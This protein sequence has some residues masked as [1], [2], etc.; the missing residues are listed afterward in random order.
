MSWARKFKIKIFT[1]LG[2][3]YILN[4]TVYDFDDTVD[5]VGYSELPG[6]IGH[7]GSFDGINLPRAG[8]RAPDGK[9]PAA[10]SHVQH[11]LAFCRAWKNQT[12]VDL[13]GNRTAGEGWP[14][15]GSGRRRYWRRRRS[16]R[17]CEHGPK[18]SPFGGTDTRKCRS[19]LRNLLPCPP[20]GEWRRRPRPA[21]ENSLTTWRRRAGG[22]SHRLAWIEW[23]AGKMSPLG[24]KFYVRILLWRRWFE[25]RKMLEIRKTWKWA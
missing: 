1:F 20:R 17:P 11:N 8:L 22:L 19:S 10:C 7:F 16:R 12:R 24:Q 5:I 13:Y 25:K 6:M 4:G 15:R 14:C 21:R 9:N 3:Y 23:C 2:K 18:A